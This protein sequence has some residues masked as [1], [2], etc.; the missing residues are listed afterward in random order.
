MQLKSKLLDPNYQRP[1]Q[2]QPQPKTNN[3]T[4]QSQGFDASDFEAMKDCNQTIIHVSSDRDGLLWLE[5]QYHRE[6]EKAKL[7]EIL[8]AKP[9]PIYHEVYDVD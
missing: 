6:F 7:L 2:T 4:I 9:N 5:L 1:V 8:G 3:Y